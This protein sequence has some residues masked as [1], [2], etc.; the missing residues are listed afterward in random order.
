[1]FSK[2]VLVAIMTL[3][4]AIPTTIACTPQVTPPSRSNQCCNTVL[5]PTSATV[6]TISGVIGV[7]MTCQTTE[8]VGLS[9]S[10]VPSAT[11]CR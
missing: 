1:M 11:N 7:D 5:P 9:C 10:F 2:L 4:A 6:I 8:L 3:A